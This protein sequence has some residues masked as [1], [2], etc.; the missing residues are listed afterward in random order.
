M[1]AIGN[2]NAA[3]STSDID[4]AWR[5]PQGR[6]VRTALRIL[7]GAGIEVTGRIARSDLERK[8][9]A[10]SLSPRERIEAKIALERGGILLG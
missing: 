3:V 10:S 7:A 8:L 6:G 4:A 1:F 9:A 5:T 2:L